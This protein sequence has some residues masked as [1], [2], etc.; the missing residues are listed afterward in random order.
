LH[1]TAS[2]L[3]NRLLARGKFRHVQVLLKLAELGS[4][5]RTADAIGMAQPTVTHTLASLEELLGVQLFERHARG[6]RP[7]QACADLLPVARQMFMG[8]A[9]SA[10][11]VTARRR[12]GGGMVRL[13]ASAAAINGLLLDALPA[14]FRQAPQIQV[15]LREAETDDLLLAIARGE[16]DL[17]ACRLPPVMPLGWQFHPVSDDRLVVVCDAGHRL[18]QRRR[19]AWKDMQQQTWLLSPTGTMA[20]EVFDSLAGHFPSGPRTYPVVTRVLTMCLQLLREEGL[21]CLLPLSF[22]QHVVDDHTL[23]VLPLPGIPAMPPLGLMAPQEGMREAASTL[24]GY[25]RG[26]A[27]AHAP[28]HAVAGRAATST[29][30]PG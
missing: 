24:F 17:M 29:T 14:F 18:A 20:R 2:V 25:L 7:T 16:V 11:M 27:S 12:H 13:L 1:Q 26:Q 10:E 19:V 3:L 22:V 4:L 8:I 15:Q 21:L 5:Q 30:S 9:E 6:V 28:V 23:A